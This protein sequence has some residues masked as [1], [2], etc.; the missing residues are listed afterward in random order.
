MNGIIIAKSLF[1]YLSYLFMPFKSIKYMYID[2]LS[3]KTIESN[4][5][6]VKLIFSIS[7]I[8]HI[9]TLII[10]L[11]TNHAHEILICLKSLYKLSNLMLCIVILKFSC[12]SQVNVYINS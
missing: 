7:C 3:L 8:N 2:K 4:V 11:Y 12:L 9:V 6:D 10:S 1:S 5:R